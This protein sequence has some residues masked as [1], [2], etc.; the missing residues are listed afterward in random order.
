[1]LCHYLLNLD[2]DLKL[3]GLQLAL[4]GF[5]DLTLGLRSV[6]LQVLL[7]C[8]NLG[9]IRY[10]IRSP[11]SFGSQ[12]LLRLAKGLKA[13]FLVFDGLGSLGCGNLLNGPGQVPGWSALE[14]R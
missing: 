6:L 4:L 14:K 2:T 11:I 12:N 13:L 10:E 8:K 1:M 5:E 3:P 9:D 7:V